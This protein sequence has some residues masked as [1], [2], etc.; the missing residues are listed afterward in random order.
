MHAACGLCRAQWSGQHIGIQQI[1]QAAA[2]YTTCQ[3]NQS[4]RKLDLELAANSLLEL[5]AR[6]S[7]VGIVDL[8][9]HH[10]LYFLNWLE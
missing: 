9:F 1:Q 6:T 4:P 7:F 10:L 3:N 8:F 2:Y 5:W